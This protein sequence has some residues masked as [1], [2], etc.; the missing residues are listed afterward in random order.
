MPSQSRERR[1]SGRRS[2]ERRESETRRLQFDRRQVIVPAALER[3]SGTDR[4]YA[5]QRRSTEDRRFSD[6]RRMNVRSLAL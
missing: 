2:F 6:D 3:R 1:A 5:L 4:R